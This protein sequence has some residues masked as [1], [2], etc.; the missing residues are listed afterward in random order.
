MF[1][2][3]I[4]N[5]KIIDTVQ[6]NE[7]A[8]YRVLNKTADTQ[9]FWTVEN[10]E[11]QSENPTYSDSV[12][13]QWN[14]Q[15]GIF[16]IAVYEQTMQNCK[17]QLFTAKILIEE[18]EPTENELDIPNVFTPNKDGKNDYFMIKAKDELTNYEITIYNRWGRKVFETHD[19]NYS[20]DGRTQGNYCSTGVYYYVKI[21][22]TTSRPKTANSFLHLYR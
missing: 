20:W 1:I 6:K 19:I 15:T 12:V 14:E 4:V 2:S 16:E 22:Q 17:G 21:Y 7:I 8:V 18:P 13:I 3:N 10:A 5:A 11:I 9:L